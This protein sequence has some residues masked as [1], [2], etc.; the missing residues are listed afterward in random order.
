MHTRSK[1]LLKLIVPVNI[2]FNHG[3]DDSL[4]WSTIFTVARE[5]NLIPHILDSIFSFG[6]FSKSFCTQNFELLYNLDFFNS[7]FF[8]ICNIM[9]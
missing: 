2:N 8:L 7:I 1:K 3:F 9:N 6:T 5:T 4:L